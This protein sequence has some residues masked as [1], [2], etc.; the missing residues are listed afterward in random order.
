M[1]RIRETNIDDA[2]DIVSIVQYYVEKTVITFN[3]KPPTVESVRKTILE[4][5]EKGYPHLVVE[6]THDSS[7]VSDEDVR[8][9]DKGLVVGFAYASPYRNEDA[10]YFT[11]E[12][13]LYLHPSSRGLGL[14]K[15]LLR[16][17][18]QR[19]KKQGFKVMVSCISV[20]AKQQ[21]VL[22]ESSSLATLEPGVSKTH[23]RE[24]SPSQPFPNI[25]P[26]QLEYVDNASVCLHKKLGFVDAGG[27]PFVGY[28]FDRWRSTRYM[29]LFLETW[30]MS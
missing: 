13:T 3:F 27:L 24:K 26:A 8:G 4:K 2:E 22:N 23:E 20:E 11:V 25:P 16:E 21:G 28:K 15:L 5:K 1:Y 19:C 7:T 9:P 29:Y 12:N 14:G 18:I 10:Y 6:M 17:L 30:D